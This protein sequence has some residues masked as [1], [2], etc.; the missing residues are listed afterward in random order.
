MYA[1]FNTSNFL[2]NFQN[3]Y[4][5]YWYLVKMGQLGHLQYKPVLDWSH[6]SDTTW[7]YKMRITHY[8]DACRVQVFDVI[9]H[10]AT[11]WLYIPS[12]NIHTQVKLPKYQYIVRMV[13]TQIN[14]EYMQIISSCDTQ[15]VSIFDWYDNFDIGLV[16]YS[17]LFLIFCVVSMHL[18][19]NQSDIGSNPATSGLCYTVKH[20]NLLVIPFGSAYPSRTFTLRQNCPCINMIL[21]WY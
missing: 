7:V 3:P 4:M 8:F 19:I 9:F 17:I 10:F 1:L 2:G 13:L 14:L 21:G 15:Q 6:L 5:K 12:E 11:I 18:P 20:V 16:G